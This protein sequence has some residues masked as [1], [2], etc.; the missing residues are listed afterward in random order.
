MFHTSMFRT[1]EADL[2]R[3]AEQRRLVREAR[4]ARTAEHERRAGDEARRKARRSPRH[5]TE[6]RVSDP[7]PDRP[8]LPRVA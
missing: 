6:G 1:H 8:A 3:V 5:G 7:E 2:I 4:E